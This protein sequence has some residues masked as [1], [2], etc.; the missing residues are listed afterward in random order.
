MIVLHSPPGPRD[1]LNKPSL[2]AL[3]I[4]VCS[5]HQSESFQEEVREALGVS[6]TE[7]VCWPVAGTGGWSGEEVSRAFCAFTASQL[8]TGET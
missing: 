4:L 8:G 7:Y 2:L 1:L 5:S 6:G 3:L